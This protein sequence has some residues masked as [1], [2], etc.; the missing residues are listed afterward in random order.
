MSKKIAIINQIG[1]EGGG[2]TKLG[3]EYSKIG[4][5]VYF[6][7][8]VQP[9]Q[10]K[11][12]DVGNI[13]LYTSVLELLNI[14]EEN[15]YDRLIFLP[16][17]LYDKELDVAL[18]SVIQIRNKYSDIELCYL[19]CNRRVMRAKRLL[20]VCR[21][22]NFFF[23]HYFSI[24]PDLC[25][26]VDNCTYMNINA[27][28]VS[29]KPKLHSR[30]NVIFSAGRVEAVRGTIAYFQ[31]I[32]SNFIKDD[33][34]YIHEGAKYRFTK[35]GISVSPQ[36]FSLFD[37]TCK[38]KKILSNYRFLN[39]GDMPSKDKLNIYPSYKLDDAM[40]RWS[41]YY[42]S[43]C[44][45]LGSKSICRTTKS[46]LGKNCLADDLIEDGRLNNIALVWDDALEYAD[47]EKIL[48]GVPVLFSIKYAQIIGFTDFRLIY[49]SFSEIPR[50][51]KELK[52]CRNDAWNKQYD[53][54][55]N[56]VVDVNKNIVKEFTKEFE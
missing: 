28:T 8:V 12:D 24:T 14:I 2:I 26:Y 10:F 55:V 35:N 42:L 13:K 49:N 45:I 20:N 3:I 22:N 56:K 25:N 15:K 48:C 47:M 39:Y 53:W 1:F 6:K 21:A 38:P 33:F 19:F 5:D 52:F 34:Y 40:F 29:K 50:K 30:N 31:S 16:L 23:D 44:C 43:I 37:M 9:L 32:D 41:Q 51:A 4:L 7:D 27:V 17:T 11:P 46:L 54:L 36:L 18:Q